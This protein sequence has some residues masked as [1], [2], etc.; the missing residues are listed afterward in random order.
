M[1]GAKSAKWA[2]AAIAVGLAAT[3]C[4]GSGGDS[5]GGGEVD[6]NGIFKMAAGEPQNP[7]VPASTMETNGAQ[8]M[9]TV[10]DQLTGYDSK[11]KLVME[12]AESVES[13]DNKTWTVKLKPDYTFHDGTPVTSDS[14]VDAWNWAANPKNNQTQASWFSDIK[15][16]DAVHP[17]KGDGTADKLAGLKVVDDTTFTIE[18]NAPTPYYAYKLG[19]YA[20]S[21]LPKSFYKDPKAAGQAPVGNGAYK[22][23]SWKHN[24]SIEIKKYAKYKGPNKAKNGGVIF[25]NYTKLEAAYEDLQSGNVDSMMQLAPRD[26]ATYKDDL[27]DRA[28]NQPYSATQTIVPAFYGKQ[29]KDIDPKVLQGL[30]M[31]IDRNTIT[32][33]VLQGSRVPATG[34]VP[35]TVYGYEK[36]AA[37]DVTTYNPAKA[38]KLIKEGGGV[39]QNKISIQYNADGGHKDWVDA[40]CN[41][42]RQAVKVEC[43]GAAK[44]TFQADTKARDA[45]EVKSMYRSG[46]VQDYPL[47]MNFIQDLYGTGR[48]GNQSDFSS[49]KVDDMMAKADSAKDLDASVKAYQ[50][51][52]KELVK[53]MPA[54]PLWDQK[55]NSG[56]S[57]NVQNV[58]FDQHGDPV[59]NQVEVLKK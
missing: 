9:F 20:F 8:I 7:L 17:E 58:E 43:T 5:A 14:Y 24:K 26:L 25:K 33:S 28:V 12:N 11:G 42:I 41:S 1:R 35:S 6:P 53:E 4:G 38:K 50:Q 16:F 59:F 22:F 13:K 46:W 19:Y 37:G 31:A 15:G 55:V 29:F 47:N 3:A 57:E 44:T 49:K 39:P 27:G 51:V 23:D 45:K 36:G 48:A 32:K 56:Y 54:I 30:S 2:A 18:L 34:F 40:V 52:E 21:P 10:F